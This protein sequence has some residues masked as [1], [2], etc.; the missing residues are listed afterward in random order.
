MLE[1][2]FG[3]ANCL[4]FELGVGNGNVVQELNATPALGTTAAIESDTDAKGSGPNL[5]RASEGNTPIPAGIQPGVVEASMIFP[6]GLDNCSPAVDGGSVLPRTGVG[7]VPNATARTVD[8][9][10]D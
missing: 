9:A 6:S 10:A 8:S 4:G 7:A 2:T 3:G 5:V 1:V